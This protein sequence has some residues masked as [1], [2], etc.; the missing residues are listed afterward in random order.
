MSLRGYLDWR[1]RHFPPGRSG[2]RSRRPARASKALVG[3]IR[4]TS[5]KPH[6]ARFL[7][8]DFTAGMATRTH[9]HPGPEAFYVVSGEQCMETPTERKML[10]EG[11]TYIVERGVHL[12]AAPKGRQNLVVVLHEEGVPWSTV[13]TDWTPS[14]YCRPSAPPVGVTR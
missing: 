3:P 12:Q 10:G 5:G 9:A 14:G 11:E 13:V 4:P 2:Q 1:R 6:I 7:E 8:A